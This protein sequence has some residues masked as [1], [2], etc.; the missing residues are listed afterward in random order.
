MSD[1]GSLGFSFRTAE[2]LAAFS[3]AVCIACSTQLRG[4]APVQRPI[5]GPGAVQLQA[6]RGAETA[7]PEKY[8]EQALQLRKRLTE[9]DLR[10]ALHLLAQSALR[11]RLSA[12][13]HEAAVAELEAGDTYQMISAYQQALAAYRRALSLSDG[14]RDQ[15]CLAESRIVRTYA[16]IGRA[17]D[18]RKYSE[19]VVVLCKTVSDKKILSA[20][21]EAQGEVSYWA[22]NMDDAAAAFTRARDLASEANDRDGEALATMMLAEAINARDRKQSARLAWSALNTFAAS[23]DQ[24]GAARAH[25]SL[26]FF[27]NGEG[28]FDRAQC[29]SESALRVFQNIGD[30]DNVAIALD[31]LGMDA[32]QAGNLEDS[33]SDYRRARRE[34]ASAQ[35]S[36][37]EAESIIGISGVLLSQDNYAGLLPLYVRELHL[38]R[39]TANRSLIGS[40]LVGLG[41]LY[42]HQHRYVE[43]E[44]K[45]LQG[46]AEYTAVGNLYGE[47]VALMRQAELRA[48]QGRFQ[49]SIDLFD[50]AAK[51]KEQTGE[52][53]DLARIDYFRARSHLN[54]NQMEAAQSEIE[55]TI[56][57]IESQRLRIA[58]FYTRAQYFAFVHE[59]Y[60]LYIQVLMA[61]DKLHPNQKY[62]Q[63]AF[64]AAER[65]KV[66]ALLD[67]L[68][69]AQ[70]VP[71]CEKLLETNVNPAIAEQNQQAPGAPAAVSTEE[72][73]LEQVQT[74][75]VD[76][77]TVL[78]EYAIGED[79]SFAWLVED[80]KTTAFDLGSTAKIR[81]RVR[82]FRQSLLPV[83]VLEHEAPV[84]YLQRRE[85]ARSALHVQSTSLSSLLLGPIRLPSGKRILIVPDGPLQ[86]IPFAALS[87]SKNASYDVPL[88]KQYEL[89][90]L[91]SASALAALRKAASKRSPPADEMTVL[92]DPVFQR[93]GNPVPIGASM[94]SMPQRSRE[95]TRA[96]LDS[97]D[98]TQIPSL[99][100]SRI[101]ALAIQQILGTARTRLALGYDANREAVI[102]GSLA[103]QRIIHFATHGII[104]TRHP[105][106]SGMVLSMFD[107]RGVYR[108]GYLRLSDIY[109]LKLSADLVV[110]SS[111]DSALG[112]DLGSEGIIGLPRGFLY[113]GARRV[114]A[115][116]WKVDDDAS[117][118]MMKALYSRLQQGDS[119]AKALRGAQL[120]LLK[121][122]RLSDPYYWAGF[123]LE[124]DYK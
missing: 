95:L 62:A 68:Q 25:M 77:E 57:M 20:A 29:H 91:P 118:T 87:I 115:S 114:I 18:A 74:E 110:L 9:R 117:V 65:S 26:A 7:S 119:P 83:P 34:F 59:Y 40:A 100:G 66:R 81:D 79:R 90:M 97:H 76:G 78:L 63:R 75:I 107:K 16:N 33:L 51:R 10:E 31:T 2:I 11:F 121:D 13:P 73:T 32:R 38:A 52:I 3:L 55:K 43:A 6:R 22:F 41:E 58:N 94:P 27:A 89:T 104:D 111:C 37:G 30:K 61:L 49:D 5:G 85:A 106:M 69:S 53:A 14:R 112:K 93:I 88:I 108:D 116:L 103:R 28:D 24:Y 82:K 35:D 42:A 47:G 15:Q 92:A 102:G 99:P 12:R 1:T 122:K 54:L 64:E 50:E 45:Y 67:L 48:E 56:D 19:E 124:G 101:E 4:D 60:S 113:A 72:L 46:F 86:Y 80:G 39:A 23:G 21:M 96:L 105:E 36:L 8:F 71:P 120:D 70:Q 44:A 109:D 17:E 98:T 84:D 123:V